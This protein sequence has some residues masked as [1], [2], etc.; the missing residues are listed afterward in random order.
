MYP[1]WRRADNNRTRNGKGKSNGSRVNSSGDSVRRGGKL[2]SPQGCLA[3]SV[4]LNY[5]QPPGVAQVTEDFA[6]REML[7]SWLE[8]E[9]CC[10]KERDRRI[11]L[12]EI[13]LSL[14][15]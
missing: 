13:I 12:S 5:P 4:T 1:L 11:V 7:C 6:P 3:A 15:T 2:P 10:A 9:T 8:T 14:K